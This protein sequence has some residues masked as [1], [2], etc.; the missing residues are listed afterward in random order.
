[1][2]SKY[3]FYIFRCLIKDLPAGLLN[4]MTCLIALLQNKCT[5]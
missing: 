3:R 5:F 4:V 2:T 1:M